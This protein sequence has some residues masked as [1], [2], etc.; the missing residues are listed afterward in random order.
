MLELLGVTEE[1]QIDAITP[2]DSANIK[3]LVSAVLYNR[4]IGFQNIKEN[5]IYGPMKIANL[6]IWIWAKQSGEGLYTV[7]NFFCRT[8]LQC[9]HQ[10]I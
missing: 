3:N 5:N 7:E 1:L 6:V 2:K 9:L 8:R 4:K 10:M